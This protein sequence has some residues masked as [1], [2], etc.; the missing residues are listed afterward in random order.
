[1][2]TIPKQTPRRPWIQERKPFEKL[3]QDDSAFYNSTTWRKVAKAHK[4]ANPL[5]VN[6]DVCGN[7]VEHTDH[8]IAL[9]DGGAPYDYG[10]LQSMCKACH[11]SK[12]TKDRINKAKGGEAG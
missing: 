2:P 4:A 12:T 1:M 10:N 7:P 8:I 9:A 6:V 3:R 11:S 5:C